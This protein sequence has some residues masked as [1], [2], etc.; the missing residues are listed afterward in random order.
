MRLCATLRVVLADKNL[1]GR[2]PQG[3]RPS[4][5]CLDLD[6][7]RFLM[8]ARNQPNQTLDLKGVYHD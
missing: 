8:V 5:H 4:R 1:H 3:L 2:N 7:V 6:G